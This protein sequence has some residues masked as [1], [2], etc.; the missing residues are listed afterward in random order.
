MWRKRQANPPQKKG[1]ADSRGVHGWNYGTD[2]LIV[3]HMRLARGLAY[4]IAASTGV[5]MDVDDLVGDAF[6][7]L[8]VAGR[9]YDASYGVDFGAWATTQIKGAVFDGI[10]RWRRRPGMEDQLDDRTL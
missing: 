10:R 3:D 6:Y 1:P 5:A 4:R 9:T 7:G 8:V 2:D